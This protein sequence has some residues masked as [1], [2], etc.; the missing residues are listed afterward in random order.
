MILCLNLNV[1]GC[2]GD[3]L[4]NVVL[5]I[6]VMCVFVRCLSVVLL[7]LSVGVVGGGNGDK[8]SVL[9][10]FSSFFPFSILL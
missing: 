4:F 8:Q 7:L 6:Y 5:V 3:V 1:I 10:L 2:V 9:S